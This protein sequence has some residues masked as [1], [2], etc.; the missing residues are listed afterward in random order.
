MEK[1][2][3]RVS[4]WLAGNNMHAKVVADGN[5]ISATLT[6]DDK[7]VYRSSSFATW[8]GAVRAVNEQIKA[9]MEENKKQRKR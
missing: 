8:D 6:L 3:K 7:V 5:T 1:R 2:S 9:R 4:E